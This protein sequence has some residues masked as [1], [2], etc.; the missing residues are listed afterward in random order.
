MKV[1][2]LDSPFWTQR[3]SHMVSSRT[4]ANCGNRIFTQTLA[5][6]LANFSNVNNLI[7]LWYS[8]ILVNALGIF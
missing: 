6:Q 7:L 3:E 2:L 8:H 5:L 4:D 1:E